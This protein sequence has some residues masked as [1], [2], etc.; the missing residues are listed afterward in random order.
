MTDIKPFKINIPDEELTLL[1]QKL[2]LAR[3]PP[4]YTDWRD[5]NAIDAA[6]IRKTVNYWLTEYDWRAEEAKINQI[7]QFTTPI[8][9]SDSDGFGSPLDIHFA[10]AKSSTPDAV[11]LLFIHGWPGSFLEVAKGLERLNGAGFHVVAPSLPGYGFSGYPRKGGFTLWKVAEVL[12]KLM[13]RLGYE[14]F[15]VQGG[16]WGSHI[17]RIL[18]LTYPENVLAVHTNM[19]SLFG[20][21]GQLA[22]V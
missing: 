4:T 2:Q 7:P 17:S 3:I 6:L 1:Q 20:G 22:G 12:R 5:D 18:G 10:H 8:A 15:F 14:R 19:V 16:D 9:L 21:V 13:L 11:P